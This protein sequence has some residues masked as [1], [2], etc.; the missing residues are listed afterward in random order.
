MFEIDRVIINKLSLLIFVQGGV[1]FGGKL[2]FPS[3]AIFSVAF[4]MVRIIQSNAEKEIYGYGENPEA[5]EG[6]AAKVQGIFGHFICL[7]MSLFFCLATFGM[8]KFNAENLLP[9]VSLF[10]AVAMIQ[11]ALNFYQPESVAAAA[12]VQTEITDNGNAT[13][14]QEDVVAEEPAKVEEAA[15]AVE[16]NEEKKDEP[17]AKGDSEQAADNDKKP[18]EAEKKP[19]EPAKPNLVC[20]ACECFASVVRGTVNKSKSVTVCLT[21]K[22]ASLPWDLI[23]SK[24]ASIGT[25]LALTYAYWSLT[26]DYSVLVI[27]VVCHL[28]PIIAGKAESKNWLS[29]RGAHLATE[30]SLLAAAATQYHL[31]RSNIA[32]PFW[33]A[34]GLQTMTL[35]ETQAAGSSYMTA[36]DGYNGAI[37]LVS[38]LSLLTGV[39]PVTF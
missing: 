27:P 9:L 15:P 20:K 23:V 12:V 3:L 14:I 8:P 26:E 18:E 7:E 11:Q 25:A 2:F 16:N 37:V 22:V 10:P 21:Q 32:L 28:V 36:E 38:T 29:R 17:E 35:S 31:F 19:E 5:K 39:A 33:D 1:V 4:Q 34:S 6:T 30:I 13:K 24:T